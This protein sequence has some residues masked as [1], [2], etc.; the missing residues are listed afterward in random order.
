MSA[1]AFASHNIEC[2]SVDAPQD[3]YAAD[4]DGDGD[5]DVLSASDTRRDVDKIAW[6]ENTDGKGTFGQQQVITTKADEA[7]SVDL[8]ENPGRGNDIGESS[9]F[10]L[11]EDAVQPA[12]ENH[13]AFLEGQARQLGRHALVGEPG[14]V[15]IVPAREDH[16][17][18]VALGG[19]AELV[20]ALEQIDATA[21]HVLHLTGGSWR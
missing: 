19:R 5:M 12:G 15:E 6:Y 20:Q 14:G 10:Q 2:C 3:V 11:V 9:P 16:L 8:V 1:I 21:G 13:E 18:V 7:H 4:L 17:D